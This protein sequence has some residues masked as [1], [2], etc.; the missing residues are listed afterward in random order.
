MLT[1]AADTE[2]S[3]E[4]AGDAEDGAADIQ[5]KFDDLVKQLVDEKH[6]GA[7]FGEPITVWRRAHLGE[8]DDPRMISFFNDALPGLMKRHIQLEQ[9]H[10]VAE[11]RTVCWT[12][13]LTLF[14]TLSDYSA[15]AV[16]QINGSGYAAPMLVVLI[17]SMLMQA[18]VAR[19]GTREGTFA[20]VGALFG[21]KPII[22]G[23]NIVFDIEPQPGALGSLAAFGWTRVCETS[24]ESIPFVVMQALALMERRSIAQ[25]ISFAISIANIAHSVASVDYG[26]DTSVIY[27][28][29][30][31]LCY[32]IYQSG[33]K[34]DGL[35]AAVATFAVGYVTAK[36]VA[37][38]VLGSVSGTMLALILIAESIALF[39]IR[40][41]TGTW[42]WFQPIGDFAAANVLSHFFLFYPLLIAAPFPMLRHPFIITPSIYSGFVAWT[43]F[44]SNPLIVALAFAVDHGSSA[45]DQRIVW[46]VL[47]GATALSV[48]AALVAFAL[49]ESKFRSTFYRHRT[50]ATHVRE[51]YWV[52]STKTDGTKIKCNDDLD[53]V[54]AEILEWY[55]KAYWPT[56]LVRLWV[57]EGWVR[58]LS[59]PPQWFTEKWQALI[60]TE[61]WLSGNRIT[62]GDA[63][64]ISVTKKESTFRRVIGHTPPWDLNAHDFEEFLNG[65]FVN[66]TVVST[67][68]KAKRRQL[69]HMLA[70]AGGVGFLEHCCQSDSKSPW[71]QISHTVDGKLIRSNERSLHLEQVQQLTSTLCVSGLSFYYQLYV[72]SVSHS[73]LHGYEFAAPIVQHAEYELALVRNRATEQLAVLT[74]TS[75][76]HMETTQMAR[77]EKTLVD[78]QKACDVSEFVASLHHWGSNDTVIFIIG[79]YCGGGPLTK[80]IKPHGG[81]EGE[82][83]WRLAFQ[84]ARGIADIHAAGLDQMEIQARSLSTRRVCL[85]FLGCSFT[86]DASR[87]LIYRPITRCSRMMGTCVSVTSA[88]I[89]SKRTA[90]A[91]RPMGTTQK[92]PR[93]PRRVMFFQSP[94]CCFAWPRVTKIPVVWMNSRQRFAIR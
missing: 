69:I 8:I 12:V 17:V 87:S 70:G 3:S 66:S 21:F 7:D 15:Y 44:L 16:L 36:L 89:K 54:R 75:S 35:F 51:F 90:L 18:F 76:E 23:V 39:L 63:T 56:D 33:S 4:A 94:W 73:P 38:A 13:L 52:R 50:M 26:F 20:T 88:C 45:I 64:V 85:P 30:E 14:D 67:G 61:E 42:R 80:R 41:V 68:E 2:G 81:V 32:G 27:R 91:H 72:A 22:D 57:R 79:E 60:P 93:S 43:L 77:E 46:M 10:R 78:I 9:N 71:V 84:L 82:E 40:F 62:D 65:L 29:N 31:P 1:P 58:W 49:M 28:A 55:A 86:P 11:K 53:A 37:V 19:Y 5:G 92:S 48:L 83:F 59:Q 47:G 34:G 25:W 74:L 6:A 24:T